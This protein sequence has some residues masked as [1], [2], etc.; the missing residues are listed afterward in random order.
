MPREFGCVYDW[1][2]GRRCYPGS[3]QPQTMNREPGG[4]ILRY[5]V[6]LSS[7]AHIRVPQISGRA[8]VVDSV[9]AVSRESRRCRDEMLATTRQY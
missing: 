7:N 3:S 2:P 8:G 1:W 5:E 6:L 9:A 4:G